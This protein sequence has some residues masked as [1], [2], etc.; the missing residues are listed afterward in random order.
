[1][2]RFAVRLFIVVAAAV[3]LP[4]LAA[5]PV[6]LPANVL[7]LADAGTAGVRPA[8]QP[9]VPTV[10]DPGL[11][12]RFAGRDLGVQPRAVGLALRRLIPEGRARDTV[13]ASRCTTPECAADAVFGAGVGTRL[14]RLHVDHGFNGSHLGRDGARAWTADEL[15]AILAAAADAP[16]GARGAERLLLR[17][18]RLD[19]YRTVLAISDPAETLIAINGAGDVG[20]RFGPAWAAMPPAQR[21]AA[22]LHELAHELARTRGKA[23]GWT[24]G[25]SEAALADAFLARRA[26]LPTSRVSRYAMTNLAEDFAESVVAY[27]YAPELLR[28]RAP[29]RLR[30]LRETVF[31]DQ[32]GR[33]AQS[34]QAASSM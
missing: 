25:W 19:R 28:H 17:D 9:A 31:R 3:V 23:E 8:A 11:P 2:L 33:L 29:N 18:D 14:L 20:L 6:S 10:A 16:L 15:D 5:Q 13:A 24:K 27:R 1:M 4:R 26:G 30:F 22:A 21:R 34:A 7:E 12:L 32:P